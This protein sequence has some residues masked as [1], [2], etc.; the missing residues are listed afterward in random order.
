MYKI[1]HYYKYTRNIL[2]IYKKY[3]MNMKNSFQIDRIEF[4]SETLKRTEK[5]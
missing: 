1:S 5:L 4:S 2:Y 3:F